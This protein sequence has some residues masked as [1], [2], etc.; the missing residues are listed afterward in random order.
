ME[1]NFVEL[2]KLSEVVNGLEGEKIASVVQ[3]KNR[4]TRV[5][6][7]IMLLE[8]VISLMV[9]FFGFSV[10]N[11]YK[12]AIL[13]IGLPVMVLPSLLVNAYWLD[14]YMRVNNKWVK[15]LSEELSLNRKFCNNMHAWFF[16]T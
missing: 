6:N 16:L 5:L 7:G 2:I 14:P 9:L 13:M 11:G 15:F 8:V 1:G 10:T 12:M 3:E 4:R